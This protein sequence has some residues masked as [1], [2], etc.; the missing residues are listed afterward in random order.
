MLAAG[1]L[2]LTLLLAVLVSLGGRLVGVGGFLGA[3][4]WS[5]V[6]LLAMIPW[7]VAFGGETPFA[8][9]TFG[10]SELVEARAGWLPVDA[11]TFYGRFLAY[12]LVAM[13]LCLLVAIR[14]GGAYRQ[15][16]AARIQPP[17]EK[18]AG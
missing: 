15:M 10:Y 1:L 13:G 4:F 5:L 7:Q 9:A 14:F 8:G 12:P 2:A 3:M 16:T 17:A 6:L 11:V 18:A